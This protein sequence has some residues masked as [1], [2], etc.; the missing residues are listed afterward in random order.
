V[1]ID[2]KNSKKKHITVALLGASF[3]TGNMGVSALAESSVKIILHFWPGAKIILLGN[4]FK[5]QQHQLSLMGRDI[6]IDVLPVRFSRNIFLPYHFFIFVCYGFFTKLLPASRLK[7]RFISRNAYFEKLYRVDFAVD[8]AGGDSF[9][10][11]Y[12]VHRFI[13]GF[14]N[15]WLIVFLGKRLILFPQ[16]YGPFKRPIVRLMAKYILKR[17]SSIYARDRRD[18]D[19]IKGLLGTN[20]AKSEVHF[21][22][23]V[24]FVL[25]AKKPENIDIVPSSHIRIK[26]TLV[27]GLNVSGLLFNGG[28]TQNNMFGLKTDYQELLHSV[29]NLLMNDNNSV[30]LLIPHVFTYPGSIENDPDACIKVYDSFNER[31]ED[32]IFLVRGRYNHNEIKYIIGL[33][34]FFVGARMHSCIAALSQ[35]VPT[36][37]IAYSKK[38]L[39]VFD[40]VDMEHCVAD[41]RKMNG[42]EI[43]KKIESVFE[44]RHIIQNHLKETVPRLKERILNVFNTL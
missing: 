18:V 3:N 1:D 7:A 16:T 38:F 17:A 34:D 21:L 42:E 28:Y 19:Y 8:I 24:A 39:G 13:L 26:E 14:L 27:I 11:I 23:D 30:I 36:V 6:C 37:G 32:R 35:C 4:V 10:D 33:C 31:F 20:D 44:D 2:T 22:S 41:A 40:S 12:G 5:P 29:I 9:S 43:L 25:D 15:K